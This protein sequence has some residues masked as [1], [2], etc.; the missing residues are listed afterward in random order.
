MVAPLELFDSPIFMAAA[1]L[2]LDKNPSFLKVEVEEFPWKFKAGPEFTCI[3][4]PLSI[5]RVLP[6]PLMV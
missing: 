6:V 2:L 3:V 4:P 5:T 1:S